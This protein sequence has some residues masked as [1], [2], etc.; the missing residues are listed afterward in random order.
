MQGMK[1]AYQTIVWGIDALDDILEVL[2]CQRL[3]L[4]VDSAFQYLTIRRQI[5]AMRIPYVIFNQ[6]AP[7]PLYEDVCKGIDLFRQCRCDGIVAIGGGSSID[8]AKCIKLYCKMDGAVNY[9]SQPTSDT[10]IPLV[11]IPTTAGTGSESTRYAVIY[12]KGQKQS[13]SHISIIPNYAVLEPEVLITLPEYQKKCTALDALCQGIESWWSIHSTEESMEYSRV[14]VEILS[15]TMLSYVQGGVDV[16]KLQQDAKEVM[17]AAN[18]AGQAINITQTTAPHAFSYKLTSLYGIPHGHAVALCLPEIWQYMLDNPQH[19]ADSRGLEFLN[20]I[21]QDIATA[22]HC[23]SANDAVG[24]LRKLLATM[25]MS[26]PIGK[27]C[28][29][30]LNILIHS[31]NPTRLKNNPVT[32]DEEAVAAIYERILLPEDCRWNG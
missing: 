29:E 8:V 11:A 3:L 27:N 4:V 10:G 30:E 32:L 31:V 7:N 21:F 20:A 25:R 12:Y 1:T 17:K 6:F 16:Q 2:Q 15:D 26:Y 5:E 14:A 23:D 19:C 18:Q 24:Y 22:L 13:V 28:Q 9:L